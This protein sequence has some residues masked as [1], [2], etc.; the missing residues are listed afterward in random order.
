MKFSYIVSVKL[1]IP[2]LILQRA[3]KMKAAVSEMQRE[4]LTGH[5]V[6]L[7]EAPALAASSLLDD[8]Q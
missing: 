3:P 8:W 4:H 6:L 5:A 2:V 1:I 7:L